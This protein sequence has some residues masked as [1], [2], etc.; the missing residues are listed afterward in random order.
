MKKYVIITAFANILF[1]LIPI[2][3]KFLSNVSTSYIL[4]QRILWSLPFTLFIVFL[5]KET[6]QMKAAL[7]NK[8]V[9]LLTSC[10]GIVITGNWYLYIW[11]VGHSMVLETSLAYYMS[12]L[13]VFLLSIFVFKETCGKW[14]LIAIAL[15]AAGILISTLTVGVFPWVSVIL[16]ITFAVYGALKKTAGLS[17]SVSLTLE[18]LVV[19]PASLIYLGM[20]SFGENSQLI[21]LPFYQMILLIGTGFISS[22]PLWLYSYGVKELPYSQV[23]FL[24]FI[25]P[26]T[27]MFLSVFGLKETLTIPKLICFLFIWIGLLIFTISKTALGKYAKSNSVSKKE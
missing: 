13:V 10:A 5:I 21:G 11:A 24:Q 22:F 2:Y 19:L 8:K 20:T 12:P 25:W 26:T 6:D 16:A 1:G 17:P 4:A 7:R 9:F 18:M 27:S 23:A 3:W 15:A 14:E